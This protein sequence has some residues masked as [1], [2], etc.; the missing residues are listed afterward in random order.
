MATSYNK[1][2]ALWK[3]A[4]NHSIYSPTRNALCRPQFPQQ[5]RT[6]WRC[7]TLA[8]KLWKTISWSPK[9]DLHRPI[10]QWYRMQ[11]LRTTCCVGR[12][13]WIE[14]TCHGK[15]RKL[16]MMMMIMMSHHQLLRADH[17]EHRLLFCD[18]K[19]SQKKSKMPKRAEHWHANTT[20]A[21]DQTG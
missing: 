18:L 15:P 11:L 1:W 3:V 12:Q 4:Q 21:P 13:R 6:C 8:A 10:Y 20:K 5:R 14:E 7:S 17:T 19:S 16:D 9:E 2:R